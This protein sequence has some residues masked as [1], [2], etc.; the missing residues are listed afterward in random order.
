MIKLLKDIEPILRCRNGN[1]QYY[2]LW[3]IHIRKYYLSF[4]KRIK[5]VVM[6]RTRYKVETPIG[7]VPIYGFEVSGISTKKDVALAYF[8][9]QT[10]RDDIRAFPRETLERTTQPL[11]MIV[12][13]AQYMDYRKR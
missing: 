3:A 8:N 11:D 2:L 9:F 13:L 7:P 12:Y 1:R 10:G 4:Y 5:H 6:Y